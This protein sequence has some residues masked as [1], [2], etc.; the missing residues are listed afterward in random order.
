[1]AG[2]PEGDMVPWLTVP[3]AREDPQEGK[4]PPQPMNVEHERYLG[5]PTSQQPLVGSQSQLASGPQMHLSFHR[6]W[7]PDG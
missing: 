3:L 5:S 1:M 7:R 6:M 2:E 4:E